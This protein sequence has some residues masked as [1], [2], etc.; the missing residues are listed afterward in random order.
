MMPPH[1]VPEGAQRTE[2]AAVSGLWKDS[3]TAVV[4]G[5]LSDLGV[6][7]HLVAKQEL[8]LHPLRSQC[9]Q[10]LPYPVSIIVL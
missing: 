8:L 4:S 2:V 7:Q 3:F 9:N 5:L 10:S 6:Q 1:S